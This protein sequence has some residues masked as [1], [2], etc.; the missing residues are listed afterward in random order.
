MIK[1]KITIEEKPLKDLLVDID[2]GCFAIPKLQRE[3]VWDG[4][5][6][7]KLLDSIYNH[8]PVGVIMIWQTPKAQ[9]LY[10]RQHYHILPPFEDTNSKVWFL[11]DGQQRISVFHH[12]RR[13][14][15]QIE[16]ARGTK[17]N[18]SRVVLSLVNE[19]DGQQIRYR[20]PSPGHYVS[21]F[22]VLHPHWRSRLN[23]LSKRQKNRVRKC[24]ERIFSYSVPLM[25]VDAKINEIRESFLRINT[26]GM[27]I[28]TADAIFTNAEDLD[29]RDVRH[30]V[31][32]QLDDSFKDIPEM[33]I[34]FAMAAVQGAKEARGPA[35]KQIILRLQKD[36]NKDMALRETIGEEWQCL[37]KCF[38]KAVDYLRQNFSV[39]NRGFLYSDYIVSLLALFFYWNGRGPSA[40]QKKRINQWFW[41]TTVG[42]RYTGRN[43]HLLIPKDWEFFKKLA[44]KPSTKFHYTPQVE[45]SDVRKAR[46]SAR[47]GITSAFYCM[48]LRRRPVSIMEDGLNDIPPDTY[49][50]SANRK[51]RHHIFSRA[52]LKRVDIP[53]NEY[54]GVCNICLLTAEENQS[55]GSVLPRKYLRELDETGTYFKRKMSRHLI[56]VHTES[57]VWV[58]DVKRGFRRFIKERSEMICNALEDEAGIRLFRRDL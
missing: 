15:S 21:L 23:H 5:K 30:E 51:D 44:N 27:K 14:N 29:L 19:D 10:L 31:R 1:K 3:F 32:Q 54:N 50:S 7:A 46:Y 37:S 41:A 57:G 52:A 48:M 36:A 13:E 34:L 38:G 20:K 53:P 42:S 22:E 26:Q 47:T 6:A 39:V 35:I 56:P 8:M 49:A 40:G 17:V 16:N 45:K 9:R 2:K 58:R 24:R 43:F 55:I 18:F 33:P 11:I 28:T 4:P 25:F 12:V